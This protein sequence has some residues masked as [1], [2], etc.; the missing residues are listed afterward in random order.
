MKPCLIR[1]KV[2]VLEHCEVGG[3]QLAKLLKRKG[4]RASCIKRI[5]M[6]Y[7]ELSLTYE[8]AGRRGETRTFLNAYL[9]PR[10]EGEEL[11][12]LFRPRY[13]DLKVVERP[14]EPGEDVYPFREVDL[15]ELLAKLMQRYMDALAEERELRLLI[16]NRG[17]LEVPILR[18]LAPR[19]VDEKLMS[20]YEGMYRM[21][22][23]RTLIN[24]CLNVDPRLMLE[25]LE[26][27]SSSVV[28]S[29]I[30]LLKAKGDEEEF[31]V[32]D[33][34]GRKPSFDDSL[35]DMLSSCDRG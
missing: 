22:L 25:R 5:L 31:L 18:L 23:L 3:R 16:K 2:R 30:L 29:A 17:P 14:V 32:L 26:L 33:L 9:A 28:Y 13:A 34:S 10:A 6:P 12:K 35:A 4:L 19:L 7:Y 15:G 8:G 27:R 21:K 20:S 1:M 24:M 11:L